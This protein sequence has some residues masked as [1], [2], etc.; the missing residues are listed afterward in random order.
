MM[1]Q[2][3]LMGNHERGGRSASPA[4]NGMMVIKVTDLVLFKRRQPLGCEYADQPG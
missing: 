1:R 4:I 2:S 3:E